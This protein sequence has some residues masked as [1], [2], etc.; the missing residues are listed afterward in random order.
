MQPV[1]GGAGTATYCKI[2]GM[3]VSAKT[4]TTNY[5]SEIIKK[6]GIYIL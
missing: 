3:D 1:V 4:G 2:A 5:T 6:Y